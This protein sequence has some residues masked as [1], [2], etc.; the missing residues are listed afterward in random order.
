MQEI[1]FCT[2]EVEIFLFLLGQLFLRGHP[3]MYVVLSGLSLHHSNMRIVLSGLS[4]QRP[5]MFIVGAHLKPS[6][7]EYLSKYFFLH[8]Q[9][10]SECVSVLKF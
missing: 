2:P 9:V 10:S 5:N 7:G 6:I 4:L 1:F 3:N 8:A